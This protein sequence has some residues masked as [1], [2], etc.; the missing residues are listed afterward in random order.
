[1]FGEVVQE[2]AVMAARVPNTNQSFAGGDADNLGNASTNRSPGDPARTLGTDKLWNPFRDSDGGPLWSSMESSFWDSEGSSTRSTLRPSDAENRVRTSVKNPNENED[3]S[4]D[5]NESESSDESSFVFSNESSFVVSNESSFVVSN[6]TLSDDNHLRIQESNPNESQEENP[7]RGLNKS[8]DSTPDKNL[9]QY[10]G[11]AWSPYWTSSGSSSDI[12]IWR[13][14]HNA[15]LRP[16]RRRMTSSVR[17]GSTSGNSIESPGRS[18]I[19]SASASSQGSPVRGSFWNSSVSSSGYT[20][21]ASSSVNNVTLDLEDETSTESDVSRPFRLLERI[22]ELPDVHN[23]LLNREEMP[24]TGGYIESPHWP[25][26]RVARFLIPRRWRAPRGQYTVIHIHV[27][28]RIHLPFTRTIAI[29]S[30][31]MFYTPAV[32]FCADELI[33]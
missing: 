16:V 5:G 17:S 14:V 13:P 21:E 29:L 11:P 26:E 30:A 12:S 6:D 8:G 9:N 7:I 33:M 15:D 2:N 19:H 22:L 32:F 23:P 3:M 18:S 28:L 10:D 25:S 20:A 31:L 24:P 4:P 27:E 1:M